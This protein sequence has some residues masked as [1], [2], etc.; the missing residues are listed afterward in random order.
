MLKL[1][2]IILFLALLNGAAPAPFQQYEVVRKPGTV[3]ER[4]ERPFLARV[5]RS[6][7]IGRKPGEWEPERL[8]VLINN[9][10][11]FGSLEPSSMMRKPAEIEHERL[12]HTAKVKRSAPEREI[13]P[14]VESGSEAAL[15]AERKDPMKPV[16]LVDNVPT[17]KSAPKPSEEPP[18]VEHKP[19][20]ETTTP[21][22]QHKPAEEPAK[23][24]SSPTAKA[25]PK[26]IDDSLR[27]AAQNYA[28][29]KPVEDSPRPA[30]AVVS[31]V[32]DAGQK[33]IDDS[34]RPT[35][36]AP[37]APAQ[38][39]PLDD[40]LRPAS[41]LDS[42]VSGAGPKAID[43]SLRPAGPPSP[44]PAQDKPIIGSLR[45][46]KPDQVN[47]PK[48]HDDSLRPVNLHLGHKPA[49]PHL[50]TPELE[51]KSAT[52]EPVKMLK[53]RS[54]EDHVEVPTT[55]NSCKFSSQRRRRLPNSGTRSSFRRRLSE[56]NHWWTTRSFDLVTTTTEPPFYDK[57]FS[58]L[59]DAFHSLSDRIGSAFS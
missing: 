33:P 45:P 51:P 29:G 36:P 22:I 56:A 49:G 20:E 46:P 43:D 39:K 5:K 23:P 17:P 15:I 35:G 27:P 13:V 50:K 58:F 11:Q 31:P 21:E 37:P 30:S 57:P 34:L 6:M 9:I 44:A 54:P 40:S 4:L 12:Q 10:K 8:L 19:A 26:P 18:K 59:R 48:P 24:T 25:E 42:A 55:R 32:S 47:A 1:G 16:I 38:D 14:V 53:T 41:A 2:Y 3:T 7:P 52:D 28:E